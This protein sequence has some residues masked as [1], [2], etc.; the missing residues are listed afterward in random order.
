MYK[1]HILQD[2]Y[3]I[4]LPVSEENK[5]SNHLCCRDFVFV[6]AVMF[7]I[8]CG[9][10]LDN[11]QGTEDKLLPSRVCPSCRAHSISKPA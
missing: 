5:I 6:Y 7:F 10:D 9:A 11:T 1:L 3:I 4:T 8:N 2:A